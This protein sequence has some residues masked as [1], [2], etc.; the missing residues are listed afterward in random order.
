MYVYINAYDPTYISINLVTY[1]YV[2]MI[3]CLWYKISTFI[4]RGGGGKIRLFRW[5]TGFVKTK[6]FNHDEKNLKFVFRG[7]KEIAGEYL[8]QKSTVD[9]TSLYEC[10][11]S[12]FFVVVNLSINKAQNSLGKEKEENY[13]VFFPSNKILKQPPIICV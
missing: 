4:M 2:H 1:M 5:F 12:C 13:A 10:C 9:Q 6:T 11:H 8:D 7:F 3:I